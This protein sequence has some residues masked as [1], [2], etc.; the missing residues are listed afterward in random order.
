MEGRGRLK[1]KEIKEW[2]QTQ[3]LIGACILGTLGRDVTKFRKPVLTVI[4]TEIRND[5]ARIPVWS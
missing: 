4:C 1:T 5:T 3:G 2:E